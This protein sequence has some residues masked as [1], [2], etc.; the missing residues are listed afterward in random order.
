MIDMLPPIITGVVNGWTNAITAIAVIVSFQQ[1]GW[2]T[3]FDDLQTALF[4]GLQATLLQILS[5]NN[6]G[7]G[8]VS[9]QAL[10]WFTYGSVIFNLG[11]STS[12]VFCLIILS[13]ISTHA[14]TKATDPKSLPGE[15]LR[16][17]PLVDQ[18]L[19]AQREDELLKEFGVNPVWGFAK[20]H[21]LL[22]FVLGA[23]CTFI[24]IGI[25]V[26]KQESNGLSIGVLLFLG[27]VGLPLGYMLF[28]LIRQHH[29]RGKSRNGA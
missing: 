17:M 12:A 21:M 10:R 13:D 23:L 28:R 2:S 16:E 29:S 5:T 14:R 24:D 25:W 8:S 20:V 3:N 18:F 6:P 19:G 15:V 22:C 11:A 1:P 7:P 27:I 26:R 4:T 9:S